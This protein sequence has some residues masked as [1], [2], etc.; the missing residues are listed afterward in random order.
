[1]IHAY[2]APAHALC[3]R[4]GCLRR[5]LLRERSSISDGERRLSLG[6]AEEG[7]GEEEGVMVDDYDEM[8]F[9]PR[10]DHD[11]SGHVTPL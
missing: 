9:K 1:M 6:A 5:R 3:G 2:K 4:P 7:Y 11:T 8:L 10:G